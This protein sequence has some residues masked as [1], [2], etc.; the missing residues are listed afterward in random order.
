VLLGR[1][2]TGI[3]DAA[4]LHDRMLTEEVQGMRYLS[5]LGVLAMCTVLWG[6]SG[7]AVESRPA[8]ES[9]T[10]A[11][12]AMRGIHPAALSEEERETKSRELEGAWKVLVD[13][14][15]EGAAAL[16]KELKAVAAANEKDDIF[17]LGAAAVLW[18]LG[19]ISEAET[20]AALWSGDVSLDA[21]YSY[22]FFTAMEAAT[23]QDARV[24]PML[25]AMLRDQKGSVFIPQHDLEIGWPLSHAFVW[26]AFGSK[27]LPA[28]EGVVETLKDETTLA[29]AVALLGLAQDL[30]ALERIRS[31][32]RQGPDT[33]RIEA[34]KAVG[35]FGH[36]QDFDFLVAGLKSKS[37]AEAWAYAYALYEYE[38]LRAVQYLIPL[39]SAEDKQL[40]SEVAE[41]LVHLV[42]PEGIE[43]LHNEAT[44]GKD[45][46]RRRMCAEAVRTLLKAVD[47]TYEAFAVKP[48]AEKAQLA[49]SLRELMEAKYRPK[50][51]D[52]KLTHDELLKAASEWRRNRRI[53]GGKYEWVED[54]HVLAA[55]T[56]ADIPL[57]LDVAAA[58]YTR[59]SDECLYE[60]K[61]LYEVIKRLGRTRYRRE[62]GL[63]VKSELLPEAKN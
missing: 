47:S 22:V 4:F 48:A 29:S 49:G 53:T 63:C 28:L 38:D 43:A 25:T 57:L 59:L 31:L 9:L 20:V 55:A 60:V 56:A 62:V 3:R 37:P 16:K 5:L 36:P 32:A 34:I 11:V 19:K 61:T 12:A 44:A 10:R 7:G 26:G 45:E 13:A 24:L 1:L 58:C 17:E 50:P 14:G 54:R 18:Q 39:L 23:T 30:K 52:A 51:G 46:E 6:A 2:K 42:T 33:A 35:L 15:P 27:G 21:H 41:C 8:S 40:G